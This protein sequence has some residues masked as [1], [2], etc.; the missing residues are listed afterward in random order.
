MRP[1]IYP[2]IPGATMLSDVIN[3]AGGVTSE[4]ALNGAY[5][6]RAVDA[7]FQ[8]GRTSISDPGAYLSASSLAL[9]DTTRLKFDLENQQNRVS[10]DFVEAIARGNRGKDV[11]LQNGDEIVIPPNP[12]HVFIRGRVLH[13]GWVAYTP[14]S[15]YEYYIEKAGGFT[16]AAVEGRIQVR[17]FGTGIWE[18]PDRTTIMPGDEIYVPGER[19]LPARTPLEIAGTII[20]ITSGVLAIAYSIFSFVRDLTRDP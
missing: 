17:K 8:L 18:A 6:N 3:Q 20:S 4:A 2:I 11:A 7:T 12:K 9:D 16:D 1:S 5:I 15:P 10:V 13:P 19:D 14:G